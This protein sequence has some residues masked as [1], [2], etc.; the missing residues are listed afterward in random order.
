MFKLFA[1]T[2]FALSAVSAV[3]GIAIP[4]DSKPATYDE[5]YLEVHLLPRFFVYID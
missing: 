2:T 5:G 3:H 1:L 4:R